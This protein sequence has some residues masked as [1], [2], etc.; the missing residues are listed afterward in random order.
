MTKRAEIT[1][2][3][4]A[5]LSNELVRLK[6][7]HYGKGPTG[8]KAYLNDNFLFVVMRDGVTP[9]E[10]T[11]IAGGD[12]ALVR[13]VRLRFQEQ[14]TMVFRDAVEK[15]IGRKVI[16]YQSQLLVNPDYAVEIFVLGDDADVA[17]SG[18]A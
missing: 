3:Q 14:M 13:T 8:A 11:L 1:G 12:E 16:G 17:R 9:V 5:A 10:Q 15:T 7:Q 18:L 6:A 2:D 4:L